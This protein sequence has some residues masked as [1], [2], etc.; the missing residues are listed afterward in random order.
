MGLLFIYYRGF[1]EKTFFY[2]FLSPLIF[3]KKIKHDFFQKRIH[4]AFSQNRDLA[5][6][7]HRKLRSDYPFFL[8]LKR[9][10]SKENYGPITPFPEKKIGE[11]GKYG[12]WT[13]AEFLRRRLSIIRLST[14]PPFVCSYVK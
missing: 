10:T 11:G 3:Q 4:P 13:A 1:F 12:P 5:G 9:I 6:I 14:G 8:N 7:L 2:D